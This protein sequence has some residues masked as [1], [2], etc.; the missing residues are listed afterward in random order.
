MTLLELI[1]S[2][3]GMFVFLALL[4][5]M[6]GGIASISLQRSSD[7]TQ[8]AFL[9]MAHQL[10]RFVILLMAAFGLFVLIRVYLAGS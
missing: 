9:G 6:F 4:W 3:I 8:R 7:P 5:K 1:L 2:I 10:Y